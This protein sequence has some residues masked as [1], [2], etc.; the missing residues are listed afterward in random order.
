MSS[1]KIRKNQQGLTLVELM[2]AMVLSLVLVAG[3]IQVYISNKQS[4]RVLEGQS[5][6]QESARFAL[7]FLTKDV[8]EAGY[9]GCRAIE[10]MN[11]QIIAG[12]PLPG[13]GAGTAIT[14]NEATSS[15]VWSPTLPASINGTVVGDTDVLTIQKGSSCGATIAN[16]V[17]SSTNGQ[18]K[19]TAPNSCS[20]SAG[21]SIMIADCTDA[22]IFRASGVSTSGT[23]QTISHGITG[24]TNLANHFCTGYSS[25]PSSGSCASGK[26]KLYG[27]EAELVKFTSLTYFIRLGAG[28]LNALWVFDNTRAASVANPMELVEGVEDMQVT[29][30]I[31]AN[32]DDIVDSYSAANAVDTAGD[33]DKVVSAQ[34]SLLLETQED[35]LTTVNQ[36]YSYNGTTVT[37]P[38]GRLRRVFTTTVG[39]RNRVQ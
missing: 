2:I 26:D 5:R 19:V 17:M 29:Y 38:D 18:L 31:D 14:G 28:G 33:W 11:V 30:G 32:G 23:Q 1:F 39:L 7:E 34:I 15:S 37:G 36:T 20:I 6:V 22:H 25:P 13:F 21:D 10:H 9:S 12:T 4:Y 3:V 27:L 16:P 35:N 24:G 8:R